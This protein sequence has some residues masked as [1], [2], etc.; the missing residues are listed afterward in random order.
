MILRVH[1]AH[2]HLEHAE[3]DHDHLYPTAQSHRR[4]KNAALGPVI[5]SLCPDRHPALHIALHRTLHEIVVIGKTERTDH[6]LT[7]QKMIR[8]KHVLILARL[9]TPAMTVA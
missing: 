9:I 1:L 6:S 4:H 8:K 3:G 7:T 2:V 5:R